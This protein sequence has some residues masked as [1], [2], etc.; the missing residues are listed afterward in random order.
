MI[1]VTGANGQL[2][3]EIIDN[4]LR[5]V[6]PSR[7]VASGR[8]PDKAADLAGRGGAVR[9]GDFADARSLRTAFRG[10][11]QVL[12]VSADKLGEEARRLHRNAI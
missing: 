11:E 7:I 4:L 2:G 9:T 10:A 5:R 12:I 1:V 6:V 8:D 3:R